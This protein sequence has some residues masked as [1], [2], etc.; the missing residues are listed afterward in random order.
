MSYLSS[1]NP[2]CESDLAGFC[3][4]YES[5]LQ[6]FRKSVLLFSTVPEPAGSSLL[7]PPLPHRAGPSAMCLSHA[8]PGLLGR[9][10]VPYPNSSASSADHSHLPSPFGVAVRAGAGCIPVLIHSFISSTVWAD[11]TLK[12]QAG[13]SAQTVLL[14]CAVR[15]PALAQLM[16]KRKGRG[17]GMTIGRW[18]RTP[19]SVVQLRNQGPVPSSTP[20]SLLLT[21]KSFRPTA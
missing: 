17:R 10:N 12:A 3:M 6:S 19:V 2:I 9:I 14:F 15:V 11:R 18:P 13:S 16:G 7:M 8:A 4:V 20:T 21:L 1:T 5:V